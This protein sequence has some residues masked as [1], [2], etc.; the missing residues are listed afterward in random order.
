MRDEFFIILSSDWLLVIFGLSLYVISFGNLKGYCRIP[1]KKGQERQHR[2]YLRD[3]NQYGFIPYNK[4][5]EGDEF[6]LMPRF[7]S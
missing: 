7:L 4:R 5:L 1:G 6:M 3:L 2:V